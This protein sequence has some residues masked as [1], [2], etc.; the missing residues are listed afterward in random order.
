[1]DSSKI[2]PRSANV[3]D[4]G[5]ESK[6]KVERAGESWSPRWSGGS[7]V[8]PAGRG[9]A[10]PE[11]VEVEDGRDIV[12]M[13]LTEWGMLRRGGK[14]LSLAEI[15]PRRAKMGAVTRTGGSKPKVTNPCK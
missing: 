1:M 11:A 4:L 14:T 13:E 12:V 9:K 10:F 3:A 5:E 7:K 8:A 15:Y 6:E 2:T